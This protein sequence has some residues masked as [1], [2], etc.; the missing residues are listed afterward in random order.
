MTPVETLRGKRVAL[1]GLGGSGLSTVRA[2]VA[3]GAEVAAW[4]DDAK[5]RERAVAAGFAPIDLTAADWRGFAAF[6]LA[7][8][9]PLTHPEA[10]LDGRQGAGG[11]RRSHRRHRALRARARRPRAEAPLIAITGTNGKSTTTALTAHILQEAE[12]E[13]AMGGN[14]GVP[15]LDLPP[16]A[17]ARIHVV[18]CSTF[19]IDLAPSLKPSVGALI[20]LTP[21]HLDRHGT[22]ENYAAIKERLVAHSD[23]ALVGIDDDVLPRDR[24]AAA[25]GGAAGCGDLGRAVAAR[26]RLGRGS[27]RRRARRAGKGRSPRGAGAARRAQRPKRRLRLRRGA[28]ARR[29]RR[30]HRAGDGELPR[31]RPS[32]GAGR[33]ARPRAV[34]QRFRRRP[35][36][37]RPKKRC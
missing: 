31:P 36:P 15:I 8:G 16:P 4:D 3:G 19:Q 14:I 2:L 27:F 10:A 12:R 33:S 21:D 23:V 30:R 18:E 6:V 13:V 25:Q 29:R 34:R 1:F 11:R 5:A 9:V 35:T 32:D 37:T 20:N 24:R 26:R 7:P 22:M 28:G 17:A